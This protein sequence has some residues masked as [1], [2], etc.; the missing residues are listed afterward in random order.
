MVIQK[1]EVARLLADD[2]AFGRAVARL[3]AYVR[4]N[5]VPMTLQEGK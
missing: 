4:A 2:K 5:A 3:I 1:D